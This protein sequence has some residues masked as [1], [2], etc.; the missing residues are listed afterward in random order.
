MQGCRRRRETYD[1]SYGTR[2]A[3]IER[4]VD[5][6][7]PLYLSHSMYQALRAMCWRS[8]EIRYT[9]DGWVSN[10]PVRS[11]V[12][13]VPRHHRRHRATSF[14]RAAPFEFDPRIGSRFAF[15]WF[16]SMPCYVI[17]FHFISFHAIP[18]HSMASLFPQSLVL[19][20]SSSP[21]SIRCRFVVHVEASVP[22]ERTPHH[23]VCIPDAI[24]IHSIP[25]AVFPNVSSRS[26]AKL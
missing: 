25:I 5:R 21:F 6:A 7:P 17:P 18:F 13:P 8:N 12:V 10:K 3:W 24:S 19:A 9:R 4:S 20:P 1:A 14:H 16:D 11:S 2:C 26:L 23:P 22:S 15:A